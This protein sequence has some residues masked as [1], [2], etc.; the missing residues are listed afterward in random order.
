MRAGS[1]GA[2][3]HSAVARPAPL[4]AIGPAPARGG[5]R[6]AD[7]PRAVERVCIIPAFSGRFP[8]LSA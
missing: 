3:E 5:Q 8:V 2:R 1:A 4:A 6:S 7:D